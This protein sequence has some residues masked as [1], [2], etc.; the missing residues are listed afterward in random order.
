MG[1]CVVTFFA[2]W[3]NVET[4]EKINDYNKYIYLFKKKKIIIYLPRALA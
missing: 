3:D 4:I 1:P 2:K